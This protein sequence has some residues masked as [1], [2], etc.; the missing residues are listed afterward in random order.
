MRYDKPN[1]KSATQ[2]NLKNAYMRYDKPNL[3]FL[4]TNE[5]FHT[6]FYRRI[7]TYIHLSFNP[8]FLSKS[9]HRDYLSTETYHHKILEL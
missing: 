6:N 5:V 8:M 9:D 2:K 1:L 7:S 4:S 3:T